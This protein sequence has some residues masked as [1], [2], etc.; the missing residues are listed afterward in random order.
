MQLL[1]NTR[2]M[3]KICDC[4]LQ[5]FVDNGNFFLGLWEHPFF[6]FSCIIKDF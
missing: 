2:E 5:I 3:L 4:K 6:R 1:Q